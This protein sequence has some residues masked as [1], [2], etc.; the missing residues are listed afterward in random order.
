MTEKDAKVFANEMESKG[1]HFQNKEKF[2]ED[3]L[4]IS[5][6]SQVGD[7]PREQMLENVIK[8]WKFWEEY[9][10][11]TSFSEFVCSKVK[12]IFQIGCSTSVSKKTKTTVETGLWIGTNA[13]VVKDPPDYTRTSVSVVYGGFK[14]RTMRHAIVS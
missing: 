6:N 4:Q 1:V 11:P 2:A 5:M 13:K 3:I 14:C 12:R 10:D 9:L 7:F 8:E